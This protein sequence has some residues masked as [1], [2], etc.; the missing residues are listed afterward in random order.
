MS[1]PNRPC[2]VDRPAAS[3]SPPP[4]WSV[5]Q[6]TARGVGIAVRFWQIVAGLSQRP[7]HFLSRRMLTSSYMLA[8]WG[9]RGTPSTLSYGNFYVTFPK[10]ASPQATEASVNRAWGLEA[11]A[12]AAQDV[13]WLAEQ[14]EFLQLAEPADSEALGLDD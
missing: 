11:W 6:G 13:E 5:G 3:T 4:G 2:R 12:G 1:A 14:A 8:E 9:R 7:I 10:N